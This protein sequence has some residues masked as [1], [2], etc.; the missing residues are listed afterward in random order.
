MAVKCLDVDE[1]AEAAYQICKMHKSGWEDR[2]KIVLVIEKWKKITM[3][4]KKV[5]A[6]VFCHETEIKC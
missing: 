3:T 2:N 4:F 1:E 6:Q 5:S